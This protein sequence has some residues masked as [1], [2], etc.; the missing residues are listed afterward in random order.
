MNKFQ[1]IQTDQTFIGIDVAK[2]SIA[3]FIDSTNQHLESLNQIKDLRQLAK[4][5]KKYSIRS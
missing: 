4:K 3:V 1:P 2:D 5:L